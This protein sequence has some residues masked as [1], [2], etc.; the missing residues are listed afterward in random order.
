MT[1]YGGKGNVYH[2]IINR[3]PPHDMYIETHLGNGTIMKKKRPAHMNIGFDLDPDQV[4]KVADDIERTAMSNDGAVDVSLPYPTIMSAAIN[5]RTITRLDQTTFSFGCAD[6]VNRINKL[7]LTPDT[8]IYCDPPYLLDTRADPR[9]R[10]KFEYT[11]EQHQEFLDVIKILPCK[12]MISGYWS[13]LYATRLKG[14]WTHSYQAVTR[15]GTLATEWIWMN[16][17][18]PASAARL[19]ISRRQLSRKRS[20]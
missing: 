13:E 12:I 7:P 17:P 14:W 1:Y 3:I 4:H 8:F 2:T 10:Y 5:G 11:T 6:S 16:Y 20:N 9:P 19:S 15:G 18:P